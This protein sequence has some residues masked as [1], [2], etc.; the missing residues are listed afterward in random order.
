MVDQCNGAQRVIDA[1]VAVAQRITNRQNETRGKLPERTSG[2]HERGRI[3]LEATLRHQRVK[4]PRRGLYLL[5]ACTITTIGLRHVDRHSPKHLLRTL[6]RLSTRILHEISLLENGACIRRELCRR[7]LRC[8]VLGHEDDSPWRVLEGLPGPK[9][10]GF[11]G[12]GCRMRD[13]SCRGGKVSP[14]RDSTPVQSYLLATATL[15][16]STSRS[17]SPVGYPRTMWRS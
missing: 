12:S 11:G 14:T 2:I 13:G 10:Q 4:L 9:I 8:V 17:R 16:F 6:Q 3:R 5:F 7:K 15:T 1:V